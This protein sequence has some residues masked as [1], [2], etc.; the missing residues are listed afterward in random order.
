MPEYLLFFTKSKSYKLWIS[1]NQRKAGQPNING[2]EF[3]YSPIILPPLNIQQKIVVNI[4]KMKSR[5]KT[6]QKQ[7]EENRKK[8]IEE[9]EKEIFQ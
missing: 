8:A 4:S 3:L 2:Q 7:A 1:S 5:I 9:F 6:L